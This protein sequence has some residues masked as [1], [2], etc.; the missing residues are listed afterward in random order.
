MKA[1]EIKN[2]SFKYE[3]DTPFVINDLSLDVEKVF[4][5]SVLHDCAKYLNPADFKGFKVEENMPKAVVH[6]FLGAFVVEKVLK[7]KDEEIINAVKYHT[8]GRA[9]MSSLEKL[10]FLADMVEEGRAYEG[11]ELLR[12]LYEKDFELCF[13]TA[14]KEEVVHLKNKGSEIYFETLNALKFYTEKN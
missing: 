14:L 8:T 9:N 7:I 10:I 6:A 1:V 4:I 13:R 11:V 12:S 3:D 2:L 5:A